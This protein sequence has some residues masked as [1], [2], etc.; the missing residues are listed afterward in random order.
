MTTSIILVFFLSIFLSPAALRAQDSPE[1]AYQKWVEASRAEDIPGLLSVSSAAKVKEFHQ[2]YSS[3]AQQ[4]EIRNL[5]KAM[6]PLNYK[7]TKTVPSKD[8]NKTSLFMD[9]TARDFFTLNDP[10]AKPEKEHVE[11]RLVKENGQ[12]KVDKQCMGKDGCGVEPEWI[13]AGYG[14]TLSLGSGAILKVSRGRPSNFKGVS[15]KGE[16][17]AVDLIFTLPE[18]G[19]TLSYFLHRSPSFAEFYVERGGER[20]TPIARIEDYPSMMK[21]EKRQPEQ[22][23]LEE[24]YSYSTS[25]SFSGQGTLSLLFDLP[26]GSGGQI[27]YV[28][29]SYGENKYSFAVK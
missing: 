19:K 26:K 28:T 29:V 15:A 23:A 4:A 25:R 24:S 21:D 18:D 20:I 7:I 13:S 22:N 6:A 17:L 14:K 8:G 10:K 12:W 16:P 11:V 5:M 2:E 27:L 3:P 9:A 1:A